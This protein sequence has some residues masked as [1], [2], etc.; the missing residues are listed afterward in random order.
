M[1]W[2][3]DK[4]RGVP[5]RSEMTVHGGP[6]RSNVILKQKEKEKEEEKNKIGTKR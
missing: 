5:R 3:D 4:G 6:K 2:G 1:Y